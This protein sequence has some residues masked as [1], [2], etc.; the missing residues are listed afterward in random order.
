[1]NKY[2]LYQFAEILK[3]VFNFNIFKNS[4]KILSVLYIAIPKNVIKCEETTKQLTS[5]FFLKLIN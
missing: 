2:Q 5:H 1:M 4:A 3:Q